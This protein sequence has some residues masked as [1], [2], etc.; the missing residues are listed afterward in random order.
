MAS[1]GAA[2]RGVLV[3][4]MNAAEVPLCSLGASCP[5]LLIPS[6]SQADVADEI[7]PSEFLSP[8]ELEALKEEE[9]LEALARAELE[10][11]LGGD[12]VDEIDPSEF[13]S[14]VPARPD[15]PV[16]SSSLSLC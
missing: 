13:L 10:A 12:V 16:G 4:A 5:L 7:D 8:E 6:L 2:A 15:L 14:Y 1:A 9:D 3:A 11:E